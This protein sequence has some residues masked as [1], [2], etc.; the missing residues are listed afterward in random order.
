MLNNTSGTASAAVT[1]APRFIH[2]NMRSK[3]SISPMNDFEMSA[4]RSHTLDDDV[5]RIFA[6]AERA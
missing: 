2:P 3:L 1:N 5:D 6:L 4:N